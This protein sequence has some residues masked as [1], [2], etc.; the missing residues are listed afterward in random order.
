[1]KDKLLNAIASAWPTEVFPVSY[2]K[3][4][5]HDSGDTLADFI[6]IELE[7]AVDWDEDNDTII[8]T[9]TSVLERALE[10]IW[11]AID[12]VRMLE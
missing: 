5:E 7:E 2:E 12:A 11:T 9:A 6:R 4:R 3:A 10:D 8:R 1:M